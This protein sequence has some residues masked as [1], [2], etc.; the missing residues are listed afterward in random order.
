MNIKLGVFVF[1]FGFDNKVFVIFISFYQRVYTR[2]VHSGTINLV[3]V[4]S[5]FLFE[6][7]VHCSTLATAGLSDQYN[8]LP[9]MEL[10]IVTP[11]QAC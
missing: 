11:S 1:I 4:E 8:K 5:E 3:T 7:F 10:T 9:R 2:E 6:E